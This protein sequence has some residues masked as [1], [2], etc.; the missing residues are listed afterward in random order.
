VPWICPGDELADHAGEGR[1]LFQVLGFQAGAEDAGEIA[2]FL[3]HKEVVLHEALDMLE[4]GVALV[5]EAF[6]EFPLAV[7]GNL[8]FAALGDEVEMAAHRPEK[9]LGLLEAPQVIPR[10]GTLVGQLFRRVGIEEEL[11]DPEQRVQVAQT[12][13]AVLQVGLH[14]IAALARLSNGACHARPACR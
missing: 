9:I 8:V 10:E 2:H 1:R 4:A 5:A 7:E 6:S 11:G 13:L 14:R 3:G 12:T